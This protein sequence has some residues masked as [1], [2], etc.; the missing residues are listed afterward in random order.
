MIKFHKN[1]DIFLNKYLSFKKINVKHES[2]YMC[3][4]VCVCACVCARVCH[5]GMLET[6]IFSINEGQ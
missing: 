1:I 3:V 6:G 4:C 5:S 2:I